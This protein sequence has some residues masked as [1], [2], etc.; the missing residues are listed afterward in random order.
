MPKSTNQPLT[1]NVTIQPNILPQSDPPPSAKAD[2]DVLVPQ[3]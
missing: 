2:F 3:P 1:V